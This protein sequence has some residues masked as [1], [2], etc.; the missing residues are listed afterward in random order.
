MGR[1]GPGLGGGSGTPRQGYLGS[2]EAGGGLS[3]PPFPPPP[4]SKLKG[5]GE[6]FGFMDGQRRIPSE[7]TLIFLCLKITF[8]KWS[9]LKLFEHF[10][11]GRQQQHQKCKSSKAQEHSK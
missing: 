4:T 9:F 11:C 7:K 5:T 10:S 3:P 2:A 8:P 6:M 1:G